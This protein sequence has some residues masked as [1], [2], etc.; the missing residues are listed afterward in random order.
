MLK[1]STLERIVLILLA[2]YTALVLLSFA[3]N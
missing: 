2:L 1:D 3:L